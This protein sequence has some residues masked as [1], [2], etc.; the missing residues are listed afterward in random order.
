MT[1]KINLYDAKSQ[2]SSLVDRAASGEEIIIAK[3]GKAMA[4][5]VPLERPKKKKR[6]L[7]HLAGALDVGSEIDEPIDV[8]L[9]EDGHS[10]D[11]LRDYS[12]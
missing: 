4:R 11:P 12:R 6:K 7:G 2:L 1:V 8:E 3:N 10:R 9:F 5:L